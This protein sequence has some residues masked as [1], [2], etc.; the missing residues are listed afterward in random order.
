MTSVTLVGERL[1]E[2]GRE[3]V[4]EGETSACADCPYRDQC[5]NLDVGTRYRVTGRREGAQSLP[6]AVHE[7][8]VTAVEVEECA[9]RMNVPSQQALAGN[10]TTLAGPCPHLDCPSHE[11]CVP[12]GVRMDRS[13]RIETVNGDPPHET[14]R[15]DRELTLVEGDDPR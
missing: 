2:P 14:C 7:D 8:D 6:C 3:F 13:Y 1:A 4:Y 11:Y 5:L 9:V 15:L 10:R 12:S